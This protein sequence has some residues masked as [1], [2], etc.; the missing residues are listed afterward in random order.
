MTMP[1]AGPVVAPTFVSAVD[2]A[3]RHLEPEALSSPHVPLLVADGEIGT[4]RRY[5]V[6]LYPD[7]RV[8]TGRGGTADRYR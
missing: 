7:G 4:Y 1:G 8:A 5:C 6:Q 2:A 3:C